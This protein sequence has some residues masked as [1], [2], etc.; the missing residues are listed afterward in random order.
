LAVLILTTAQAEGVAE[1]APQTLA[2]PCESLTRLSG[3]ALGDPTV[4]IT[5]AAVK[6]GVSIKQF[7][8]SEVT[9]LPPHCE[10][11]GK[12]HDR[13][14]ANGQQ[15][16]IKFHMRLPLEWSGRFA[17]EGG[18]GTNGSVGN[19]AGQIEGPANLSALSL[20]FA[21]VSQD[22]GHDN[23]VNLDSK[24]QGSGTF[25]FDFQARRDYGYSS[26]EVVARVAKAIVSSAY[27][28]PPNYSYFIG[29][30]KGGQE[31]MMMA[32]RY[33]TY[34]DGILSSAPG[35][36]LPK[37]ALATVWDVQAVAEV[38][39]S[40]EKFDADGA[41]LLNKAY[42]DEDLALVSGAVKQA[43]DALDGLED[44]MVQAVMQCTTAQVSGA[45]K[46]ITCK[47][48][49]TSA[50]LTDAQ[51]RGLKRMF[52]GPQNKSGQPLYVSWPWDPGIGG[53]NANG[54]YNTQWR[55]FFLG[56][57]ASDTNNAGLI[58]LAMTATS[59]VFTTPPSV[60]PSRPSDL[61]K[62][63]LAFDF[64]KDSPKIFASTEE[65]PESPWDIMAADSLDRTQ[66]RLHGGKL[67]ILHGSIDENFSFYD[68]AGWWKALDKV[69]GGT[70]ADFVRLFNVPGMGHCNGGPSTDVYNALTPLINWV[71]KG[72]A[73]DQIPARANSSTPWPGRTRPLCRFPKMAVYNGSGDIENAQNFTCK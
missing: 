45:L 48:S 27:G 54:S 30:S 57:Y 3:N 58:T 35:F 25:G 40:L 28:R 15:Y 16:V 50:C 71:E 38:A 61:L 51:I 26:H 22:S 4:V 32:Q 44:G 46:E 10:L 33:P 21:V 56:P 1:V 2:V 69:E 39:R 67:L 7:Y 42:S 53:K 24:R 11:F 18:G 60:V 72:Q 59:A 43:C 9:A 34:F 66:F 6:R 17:F 52:D 62:W 29:C 37:L 55:D 8:G 70:A 49:K 13:S 63:A 5:Q 64:D 19:A 12:L 31:G 73:P 47:G 23:H 68:T 41:P 14:G 20:G 36:S 65:F